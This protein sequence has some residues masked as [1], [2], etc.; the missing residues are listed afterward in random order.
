MNVTQTFHTKLFILRCNMCCENTYKVYVISFPWTRSLFAIWWREVWLCLSP[1]RVCF[2]GNWAKERSGPSSLP[3]PYRRTKE[4]WTREE[5]ANWKVV[6]EGVACQGVIA[7]QWIRQDGCRGI[8]VSCWWLDVMF[9]W[10]SSFA[11]ILIFGPASSRQRH[12]T[13]SND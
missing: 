3:L 12:D 10:L 5:L 8:S 9:S 4:G 11:A 7:G 1:S 2:E 13:V 6:W